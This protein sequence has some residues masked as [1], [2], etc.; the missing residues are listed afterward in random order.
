M[1]LVQSYLVNNILP[2]SRFRDRGNIRD[3]GPGLAAIGAFKHLPIRIG[4]V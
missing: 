1:I 4:G 3:D 2:D